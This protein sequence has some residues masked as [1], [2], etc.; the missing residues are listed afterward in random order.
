[1]LRMLA[2]AFLVI[3]LISLQAQA[4]PRPA[5]FEDS[6]LEQDRSRPW[7][8]PQFEFR[9]EGL[10]WNGFLVSKAGEFFDIA[11]AKGWRKEFT[12]RSKKIVFDYQRIRYGRKVIFDSRDGFERAIDQQLQLVR[13]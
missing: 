6:V 10:V 11:R 9:K 4:K 3:S 5:T 7:E 1:M 2:L 13:Q 12:Y 8:F